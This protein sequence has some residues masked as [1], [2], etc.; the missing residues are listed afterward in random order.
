MAH[1]NESTTNVGLRMRY[2]LVDQSCRT[3]A[4]AL[5]AARVEAALWKRAVPRGRCSRAGRRSHGGSIRLRRPRAAC[6]SRWQYLAKRGGSRASA[7]AAAAYARH[8]V[9]DADPPGTRTCTS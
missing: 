4:E 1:E 6:A 7:A 8:A 5:K 3:S 9:L 2:R